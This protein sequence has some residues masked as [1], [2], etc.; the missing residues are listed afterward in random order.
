MRAARIPPNGRPSARPAAPVAVK[1]RAASSAQRS[2]DLGRLE[3][4]AETLFDG[5][6]LGN[7]HALAWMCYGRDTVPLRFPSRRRLAR[8]IHLTRV[9]RIFQK[10]LFSENMARPL[11]PTSLGRVNLG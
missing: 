5:L 9:T 8:R 1:M 2:V 11:L 6:Q 3:P 4:V 7:G 10:R